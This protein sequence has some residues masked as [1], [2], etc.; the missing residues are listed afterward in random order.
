LLEAVTYRVWDDL[1]GR[2]RANEGFLEAGR[3]S[4]GPAADTPDPRGLRRSERLRRLIEPAMQAR[5]HRP[6]ALLSLR[7]TASTTLGRAR[8]D[9]SADARQRETRH[10]QIEQDKG[11]RE[12]DQLGRESLL[13]EGRKLR[14][15]PTWHFRMRVR[16]HD[17][18]NLASLKSDRGRKSRPRRRQRL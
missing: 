12:P 14:L 4:G 13:V 2:P 16:R 5:L 7:H 18:R 3:R 17:S 8:L 9:D 6:G 11:D 15:P 10:Q 1:L